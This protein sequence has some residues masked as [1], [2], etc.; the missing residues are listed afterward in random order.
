MAC[1]RVSPARLALT[2]TTR[3]SRKQVCSNSAVLAGSTLTRLIRMQHCDHG[4]DK[5]LQSL[6]PKESLRLQRALSTSWS[7]AVV[8]KQPPL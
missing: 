5:A 3:Q 1:L 8:L 4:R 2:I 7:V 6:A